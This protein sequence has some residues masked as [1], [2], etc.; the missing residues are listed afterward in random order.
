MTKLT[1]QQSHDVRQFY[2]ELHRK[3]STTIMTEDTGKT[4]RTRTF[5]PARTQ[6]RK[7]MEA[8][9]GTLDTLREL[10]EYVTSGPKSQQEIESYLNVQIAN[11]AVQ[12]ADAFHVANAPR[13]PNGGQQ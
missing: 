12:L 9:S 4:R 10:Q 1:P 7:D 3:D 13:K 6:A 8:L 11:N 2:T 5:D